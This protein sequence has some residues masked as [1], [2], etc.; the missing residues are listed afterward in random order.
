MSMSI[1]LD[2]FMRGFRKGTDILD[3]VDLS[4]YRAI[5]K[6]STRKMGHSVPVGKH[7]NGQN[8][9]AYIV[10]LVPWTAFLLFLLFNYPNPKCQDMF[11][12]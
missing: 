1:G 8:Y 2:H 7:P 10:S 5:R 4:S 9:L 11:H 3:I 6:L 12:S